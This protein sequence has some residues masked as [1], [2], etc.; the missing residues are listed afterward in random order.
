MRISKISLLLILAA[1]CGGEEDQE[2]P[3]GPGR[4]DAPLDF[5]RSECG[6]E[7]FAGEE[8][9]GLYHFT[10]DYS[11][12]FLRTSAAR[13]D[14]LGD[15][16]FGGAVSGAD[17]GKAW[18]D[19]DELFLYRHVGTDIG[20]SS[21]SVLFCKR[22]GNVLSGQFAFCTDGE[23]AVGKVS[24]GKVEPL[25]EAPSSG[26]TEIGSLRDAAWGDAS[27]LNVRVADNTAYLANQ[28]DGMRIIDIANPATPVE[29]G[30]IP[31][32]YPDVNEIYNDV[33]IVDAAGAR[34]ILVASSRV[35]IRVYDVTTPA[36]PRFVTSFGTQG[37]PYM[38]VH[39]L[40]VDGGRAYL[41]N[42]DIGLEIWDIADPAQPAR[43]GTYFPAGAPDTAFLHDLYV[44]GDR[45][46]LNFWSA[47]MR[48]IDVSN[49]A[50][51][52]EVGAFTSYGN[53][54]SHSSWVTTVAGRR[55][56]G[57]GDEEWGS[58]L[59]L[60]DV[61]EGTPTFGQ[62]IGEWQTRPEVSAHNVMAVGTDIVMTHYQ[63][64]VRIIDIS[65]PARP[66]TTAWF[67]T[68]HGYDRAYG[69][70]FFEG[71]I[72]IDIDL[73]R[74]RLYVADSHRG[75]VILGLTSNL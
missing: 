54:S 51:P 37:D 57:H 11:D 60:V 45:A 63:D 9:Q 5:D 13:F 46:Y 17:A 59:R 6:G 21:R 64:G 28:G 20:D 55:I 29:I 65:D 47:G 14:V 18:G 48:I 38:N 41:A 42:R 19:D 49:P 15:G 33:K 40:F 2:M 30:H 24:G 3:N 71:A 69:Y 53:F 74:Q 26:L 50:A 25:A 66:E 61:T 4:F 7:P 35:G 22:E 31:V 12:G 70:S 58:H 36:A 52:R 72:G 75:L 68:W 56:A 67:N 34:Y 27:S 8:L 23:C 39:T 73:P 1:A 43:L 32:S 10:I 44:E 62:Q 16:M